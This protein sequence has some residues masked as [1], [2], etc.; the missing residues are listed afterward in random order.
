EWTARVA[1]DRA[2]EL[3]ELARSDPQRLAEALRA[4]SRAP[5]ANL[6]DLL[7]AAQAANGELEA[8]A[9]IADQAVTL[10]QRAGDGASAAAI[11]ARRDTYRQGRAWTAPHPVAP[12]AALVEQ[13]D[14]PLR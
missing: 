12:H 10:A 8:A 6:L 9:E 4:Q 2:G 3:R 14:S 13:G 1:R 5:D 11:A 7:A